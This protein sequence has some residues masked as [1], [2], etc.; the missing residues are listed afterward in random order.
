MSST[1][2]TNAFNWRGPSQTVDAF[3]R[4]KTERQI[5]LD[6]NRVN[7]YSDVG[8]TTEGDKTRRIEGKRNGARSQ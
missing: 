1:A 6:A 7:P 3:G 5:L 4:M 2:P 8:R